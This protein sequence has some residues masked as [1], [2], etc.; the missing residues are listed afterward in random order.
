VSKEERPVLISMS[1]LLAIAG[2]CALLFFAYAAIGLDMWAGVSRYFLFELT[3][4]LYGVIFAALV[5]SK[6]LHKAFLVAALTYVL[7]ILVLPFLELSPVKPA[8]RAVHEIQGGMSEAQVRAIL[9]RNFP[10]R[11]HFKR[12]GIGTLTNNALSFVLDPNDGRYN[13][14][15]VSIKFSEGKCVSAEFLAD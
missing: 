14:A 6:G 4:G 12:P 15:I 5:Y 7:F 3:F 11:S 9:D 8:V 2:F 13:A 10:E 1:K